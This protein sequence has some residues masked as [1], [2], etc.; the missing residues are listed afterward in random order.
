MGF[1]LTIFLLALC[2]SFSAFSQKS[3]SL[4]DSIEEINDLYFRNENQII[5]LDYSSK[6]RYVSEPFEIKYL[7]SLGNSSLNFQNFYFID[8]FS[9]L[10]HKAD[11]KFYYWKLGDS[12]K[13]KRERFVKKYVNGI[14]IIERFNLSK[15]KIPRRLFFLNNL[16]IS[17]GKFYSNKKFNAGKIIYQSKQKDTI[18]FEQQ[19]KNSEGFRR[20]YLDNNL[21]IFKIEGGY[22]DPDILLEKWT[23]GFKIY[24]NKSLNEVADSLNFGP[25]RERMPQK[26]WKFMDTIPLAYNNNKL[27]IHL[28]NDTLLQIDTSKIKYYIVDFWYLSCKPCHLI[29]PGLEAINKDLDT[30]QALFLGFDPYDKKEDINNFVNLKGFEIPEIDINNFNF[31]QFTINTN[32][33]VLILDENFKIIKEFVGYS[34]SNLMMIR[35]FLK[36][37]KLLL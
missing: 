11:R 9:Y 27:K 22:Y 21:H 13:Y 17:S 10:Y 34:D 18:I 19:L 25:F 6:N 30:A 5:R 24:P 12:S 23:V 4:I 26:K 1:R 28:V 37:R 2:L 32:P 35:L 15:G 33:T 29:K 14:P 31:H 16:P 8:T 7:I 20:L 36:Q 3:K